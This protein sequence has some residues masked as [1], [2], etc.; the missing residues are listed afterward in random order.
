VEALKRLPKDE[1]FGNPSAKGIMEQYSIVAK[2]LVSAEYDASSASDLAFLE[3]AQIDEIAKQLLK[4]PAK[5]LKNNIWA[6]YKVC[7]HCPYVS[8]KKLR[9]NH[10]RVFRWHQLLFLP[11]LKKATSRFKYDPYFFNII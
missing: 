8:P 7:F 2:V 9:Y 11:F 1:S 5:T 6:Y 3:E 4:L 10:E